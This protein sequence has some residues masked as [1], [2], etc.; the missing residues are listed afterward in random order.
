M[1]HSHAEIAE[2][3]CPECGRDFRVEVW[4]IVDAAERPDL[5]ARIEQDTLH[6][7]PCPHCG[8]AGQVDAP[9]LLYL[10][11]EASALIFSPT[12]DTN[13]EQNRQQAIDLVS[14][15]RK[16]MGSEWQDAWLAQMVALPRRVVPLALAQG[17]E[18]AVQAELERLR[19]TDPEAYA[20]L[21]ADNPPSESPPSL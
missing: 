6:D 16:S 21:T 3:T 19:R 14:A 7:L 20:R 11:G 4:L 1:P 18:A 12:R 13:A 17:V 15:F 10:P 9:L 2:L 5:L 8:N